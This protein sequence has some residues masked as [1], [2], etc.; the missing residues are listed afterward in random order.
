MG[1]WLK[2]QRLYMGFLV[3]FGS[4][5]MQCSVRTATQH[6]RRSSIAFMLKR[7]AR[8]GRR[9]PVVLRPAPLPDEGQG[10]V[11]PLVQ[12]TTVMQMQGPGGQP[13]YPF[14]SFRVSRPLLVR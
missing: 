10:E 5:A 9:F 8:H 14:L 6:A 13:Y 3:S 7:W 1:L 4:S 2:H 12:L 11:Q